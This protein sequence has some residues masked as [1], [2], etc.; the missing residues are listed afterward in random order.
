MPSLVFEGLVGVGGGGGMITHERFIRPCIR[1][2]LHSK[3]R[4]LRLRSAAGEGLAV[5]STS[6]SVG[7]S[8]SC[9]L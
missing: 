8:G 6:G 1:L 9:I 4:P 5:A 7:V 3:G 2:L